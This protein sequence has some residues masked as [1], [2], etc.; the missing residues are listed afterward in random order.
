M[1]EYGSFDLCDIKEG[2]TIHI[3]GNR[4]SG[5]SYLIASILQVLIQKYGLNTAEHTDNEFFEICDFENNKRPNNVLVIDDTVEI[6]PNM[7]KL[8]GGD[9]FFAII[10]GSNEILDIPF[11]IT[12][13]STDIGK[14]GID[15]IQDTTNKYI[16]QPSDD[17]AENY[18]EKYGFIV[19]QNNYPLRTCKAENKNTYINYCDNNKWNYTK[20]NNVLYKIENGYSGFHRKRGELHSKII[21]NKNMLKQQY[22]I[23]FIVKYNEQFDVNNNLWLP[24]DVNNVV[25]TYVALLA[26]QQFF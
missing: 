10:K 26:I 11:D 15:F 4:N 7:L 16:I 9:S 13:I 21:R 18:D 20:L 2:D 8:F 24:S 17:N 23:I 1:S 6:T 5:I 25:L 14:L 22:E 12:M 19:L 3:I